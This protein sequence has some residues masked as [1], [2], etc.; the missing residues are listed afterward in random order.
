MRFRFIEAEKASY[1]IATL[2]RVLEV[3]TA[4]FYEWRAKEAKPRGNDE[5]E[6]MLKVSAAFKKG[7]GNY[8][9][10]RVR[11]ELVREGVKI[12]LQRSARLMRDLGL[13]ARTKRKFKQTTD[14]SHRLPVAPNRLREG[15]T[16]QKPNEAWSTDMTYVWTDEGWL[17]LC[18]FLD[19]FSRSVVGWHMQQRMDR[20][21][22]ISALEAA[23]QR[24]HPPR[25][26]VVHSD[27][28]SQYCSRDFRLACGFHGIDQS[29]GAKGSAYDNAVTETFFST[30]KKELIYQRKFL[31]RAEAE[32]AIFEFIEVFYN[33]QRLHSTLG[34]RTPVE[35]EREAA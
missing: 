23:V 10:R 4:A 28:G 30:L 20:S 3:S 1:P 31:T 14:S 21:L 12:G 17:Y 13:R 29:M 6:I 15:F 19:L 7:R 18:V 33:R 35:Y 22:V 24:R 34:Y 8:G 25:G 11:A 9:K 16:T 26:L 2:C 5:D 32:Q 27:R